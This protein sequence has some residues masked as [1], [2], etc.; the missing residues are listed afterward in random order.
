MRLKQR[1]CLLVAL[2]ARLAPLLRR[3][4]DLESDLVRA[5]LSAV[6]IDRPIF[7]TRSTRSGTT[8]LLNLLAQI[9][10]VATQRSCDFP[11]L[12]TPIAWNWLHSRMAS[13]GASG[14]RPHGDRIYITAESPE[15][16]E[17]PLWQFFFPH[18]H[19]EDANHILDET[20]E[21]SEFSKSFFAIIFEKYC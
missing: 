2:S 3:F 21:A 10:G 12:W 9:P 4:G 13:I 8:L 19:S 15:A 16:F 1:D 6:P 17:E 20:T 5:R 7:I 11:F 14:E 18:A